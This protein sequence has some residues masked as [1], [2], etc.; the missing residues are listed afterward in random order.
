MFVCM[1]CVP[2]RTAGP[3]KAC[4]SM[5]KLTTLSSELSY[6]STFLTDFSQIAICLSKLRFAFLKALLGGSWLLGRR[7]GVHKANFKNI[8][9]YRKC[10]SQGLTLSLKCSEFQR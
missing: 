5:G 8:E 9:F 6:L 7:P 2:R 1:Q 3:A 4:G 10:H